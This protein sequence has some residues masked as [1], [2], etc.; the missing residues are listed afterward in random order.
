MCSAVASGVAK[1]E[2]R[3]VDNCRI[4]DATSVGAMRFNAYIYGPGGQSGQVET[5][6]QN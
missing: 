5:M 6:K 1:T 2:F 3:A 4:M